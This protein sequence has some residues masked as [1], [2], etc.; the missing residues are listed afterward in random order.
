[1]PASIAVSG[2]AAQAFRLLEMSPISSFGDD[3]EQ[4]ISA[5]DQYPVALDVCLEHGDW[6]FASQPVQLPAVAEPSGDPHLEFVYNRPGDFLKMQAVWPKGVRW[7][8]DGDR[9][10][11]DAPAPLFIRYTR[12]LTDETRLPGLFRTAVSYRLASFLA[13]RW[14]TSLNRSETLRAASD[15]YLAQAARADRWSASSE[16]YDGEEPEGDWVAAALTR[17]S[18]G[19]GR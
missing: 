4:G 6:S 14:T 5:T 7:R 18:A 8:M 9:L 10:R 15:E 12:R 2:I 13:P 1:M 17:G 11:A 19:W 3:S 16:R